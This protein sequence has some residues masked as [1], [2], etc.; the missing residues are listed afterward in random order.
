MIPC[1]CNSKGPRRNALFHCHLNRILGIL[2]ILFDEGV[3]RCYHF[4]MDKTLIRFRLLALVILIC[5]FFGPYTFNGGSARVLY[6][7]SLFISILLLSYGI[8]SFKIGFMATNSLL[9]GK[10]TSGAKSIFFSIVAA[11]HITVFGSWMKVFN[12]LDQ[13]TMHLGMLMGALVMAYFYG[14]ILLILVP[15]LEDETTAWTLGF[16]SLAL[17][18][19]ITGMMMVRMVTS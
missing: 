3:S 10:S 5:G 18:V 4:D 2:I 11:T 1:S 6:Q 7:P 8:C 15:A 16:L 17:P 9:C 12:S 14:M 13:G 19:P